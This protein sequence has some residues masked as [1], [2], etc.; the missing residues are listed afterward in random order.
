MQLAAWRIGV[1]LSLIFAL[2]NA[3]AQNSAKP[4]PKIPPPQTPAAQQIDP[5]FDAATGRAWIAAMKNS[6]VGPFSRIRYFCADGQIL[7]PKAYICEPFGGGYQHGEWNAQT[8][9]L[10]AAGYPVANLLVTV[11]PEQVTGPGS[12]PDLLAIMVIERFLISYDDGWIYRKA[13]YYRGAIQDHNEKEA[14]RSLLAAITANTT[15]LPYVELRE[16]ARAFPHGA[17]TPSLSKIRSM[18]VV[19]DEKDPQ[20]HPL[21]SRIHNAPEPRMRRVCRLM[22]PAAAPNPS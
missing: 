1:M 17:D 9:K 19:L 7:E 22:Q 10:R 21:R 16:A 8:K 13:Q 4:P 5:A 20:F 12:D 14:A 2:A 11:A 6:A 3:Q 18:A 15:Q